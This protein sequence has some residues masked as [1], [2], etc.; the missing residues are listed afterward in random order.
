M[1]LGNNKYSLKGLNEVVSVTDEGPGPSCQCHGEVLFKMWWEDDV[2]LRHSLAP[3][4]ETETG[5]VPQHGQITM[6]FTSTINSSNYFTFRMSKS[7]NP[8]GQRCSERQLALGVVSQEQKNN[9]NGLK[10]PSPV[11]GRRNIVY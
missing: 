8:T 4:W 6:V 3:S 10:G 5:T 9:N 1:H 11:Y 7:V 2:T